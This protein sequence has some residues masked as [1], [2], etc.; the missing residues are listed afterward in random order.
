MFR[1]GFAGLLLLT[2]ASILESC[3]KPG[4]KVDVDAYRHEIEQWQQQRIARTTS[5]N[6]WLTLCGLFW[7]KEGENKFGSDSSNEIVFPAGKAPGICGSI[8]LERGT[9]RLEA[10]SGV[11]IKHHDSVVTSLVLRSDEEG[12]ADPTVLTVNALSFY[13]I[14]R[15]GQ[16]AVRVKDRENPA[17][18]HFKGLEYFPIDLKWRVEAKFEPYVPQKALQIASVVGTVE[19]DTC[20][21]ALSFEV[22]GKPCRLDVVIEQG[23]TDEFFVMFSD[24]TSGKETYKMGRQLYTDLPDAQNNVILD[25]NKAY[26]WPCVFTEYATCPIPPAQNHL[27]VRVEAGEKMYAVHQ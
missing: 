4:S 2:A 27:L 19:N 15:A 12:A 20:P 8:Y 9:L 17:L 11:E 5:D 26:N 23:T 13:A 14:Q 16:L 21:G 24:E 6:G 22:D 7:L 10:R 1:H 25:F 3:H 18:L